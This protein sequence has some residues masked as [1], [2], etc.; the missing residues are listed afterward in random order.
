[1]LSVLSKHIKILEFTISSMLRRRFKNMAI[2]LVFSF[3]VFVLSSILLFT[4]SLRNE[5][6]N[7][8]ISS[9]DLVVQRIKAGRH[10]LIPTIYANKI[11]HIQGVGKA[12]PRIWGYYFDA[13][14]QANYTIMGIDDENLR[15]ISLVEG[16]FLK[17]GERGKCVIGKGIENVPLYEEN[18]EIEKIYRLN[19]SFFIRGEDGKINLLK[20]IGIFNNESKLLTNDL[21][22]MKTVDARKIF[23][24]P[25]DKATDIV[26]QTDDPDQIKSIATKIRETL[27]ETRV[28]AREEI[29]STYNSLFNWNSG[30]VLTMSL[31][32]LIALIILA[33]DKVTGLSADEKKEIGILKSIGWKMPDIIEL[34]FWEGLCLSIISFLTGFIAAYIHVFHAGA[35]VMSAVLKGWSLIFPEFNLIPYINF[36]QIS[37]LMFVTVIPYIIATIAP[38]WKAAMAPPDEVMR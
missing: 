33:W 19:R 11:A 36:Y 17:K 31:G 16:S 27:P 1:M 21:V 4:Y 10:D 35:S 5:A 2:V 32:A 15:D 6:A 28:I 14:T 24:I 18:D 22:V 3:V 30:I 26:I 38:S 34:K 20:I 37:V 29:L 23:D 25:E 12:I 13:L 8:L 9:P 7:V